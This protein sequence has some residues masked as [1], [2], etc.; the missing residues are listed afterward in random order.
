MGKKMEVLALTNEGVKQ[1][2]VAVESD[3]AES[4]VGNNN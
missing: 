3:V 2:K 1:R 4:T